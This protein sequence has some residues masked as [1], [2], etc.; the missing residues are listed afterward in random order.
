MSDD[1]LNS[2]LRRMD[3][4]EVLAGSYHTP[5]NYGDDVGAM[6]KKLTA[7]E[8]ELVSRRVEAAELKAL[9]AKKL[10]RNDVFDILNKDVL[11]RYTETIGDAVAEDVVATEKRLRSA[12]DDSAR[13]LH[14]DV[15]KAEAAAA[16]PRR[17]AIETLNAYAAA[18]GG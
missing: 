13:S 11:P 3:R 5:P 16:A 12:I 9:L 6:K 14:R 8:G 15:Q 17:T 7:M 18:I 10:T 4:L 2:L 1:A